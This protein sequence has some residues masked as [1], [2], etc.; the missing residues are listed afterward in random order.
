VSD[1]RFPQHLN[2]DAALK[3]L[4][5]V[6]NDNDS[7]VSI[8]FG[9]LD[10][11]ES[12]ASL[13]LATELKTIRKQRRND[14]FNAPNSDRETGAHGYL[15][16]IGFFRHLGLSIGKAPG[17]A[18]G[19]EAYF[20]I[21]IV[22]IRKLR[23]CWPAEAARPVGK[24][25]AFEAENLAKILTQSNSIKV[26]RP[27]SYCLREIIRNVFEHAQTDTCALAAQ[28][29][30]GS[31]EIAIADTGV[32]ILGS[33]RQTFRDLQ[34]DAEAL[35]MALR[36]GVSRVP[37]EEAGDEDWGNSGFG[38]YVLSEIGRRAG[39][40]LLLSGRAYVKLA[41]SGAT[42]TVPSRFTGT[43]LKLEVERPKGKNFEG[44]IQEIIKEGE[45][46]AATL[47]SPRR[48]SKSTGSI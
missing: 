28:R 45:R 39:S 46:A 37:A 1:H 43:F 30:G 22:D 21:T 8:D 34:D 20:P 17:Q 23:S 26:W 16:H 14:S 5:D 12:S 48:A 40:F 33:L 42:D 18:S 6:R 7:S 47:P 31:I 38:L 29:Y 9:D 11:A 36:P 44:F 10:Y 13:L 41:R 25:V 3:L 35:G 2:V 15:K 4:A 32:G 19:S 24:L 27:V